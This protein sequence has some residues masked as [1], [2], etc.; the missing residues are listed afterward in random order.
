MASPTTG[1][2]PSNAT[3]TIQSSVKK[4]AFAVRDGD[5]DTAVENVEHAA[6]QANTELQRAR[7]AAMKGADSLGK[8]AREN[9]IVTAGVVFGAG[10]LVGALLYR[11]FNPTPTP[12]QILLGAIRKGGMQASE[13]ILSGVNQARR[14]FS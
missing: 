10:A 12:G 14:T 3:H 13:T 8:T 2:N 1:T 9:P 7:K 5:F 6:K 11:V 4:A